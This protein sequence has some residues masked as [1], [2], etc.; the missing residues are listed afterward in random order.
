VF[1]NCLR[2]ICLWAENDASFDAIQRLVDI[3]FY[4]FHNSD[5]SIPQMLLGWGAPESEIK[6]MADL[7]NSVKNDKKRKELFRKL[8]QNNPSL[9]KNKSPKSQWLSGL[10]KLIIHNE[11][12]AGRNKQEI[13][14]I[15]CFS[16]L[17]D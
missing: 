16:V 5:P 14:L 2:G 9:E 1:A 12:K 15:E 17:H 8:V 7:C 13:D 4:N 3:I 6:R 10:P 11:A